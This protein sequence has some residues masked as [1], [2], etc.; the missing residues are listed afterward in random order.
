MVSHKYQRQVPSYPPCRSRPIHVSAAPPPPAPPPVPPLTRLHS[1]MPPARLPARRHRSATPTHPRV[2]TFIWSH[3]HLPLCPS[4]T[5]PRS[6]FALRRSPSCLSCPGDMP[7]I[8]PSS[9]LGRRAV[10]AAPAACNGA[11]RCKVFEEACRPRQQRRRQRAQRW[12][13]AQGQRLR[14]CGGVHAAVRPR[15]PD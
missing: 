11:S 2:L 5:A 8:L 12:L 15:R 9:F 10:R 6:R 7:S 13:R 1:L 4:S 3:S 14:L